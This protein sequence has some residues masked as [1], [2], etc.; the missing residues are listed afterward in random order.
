MKKLLLS[1][2]LALLA[3][4]LTTSAIAQNAAGIAPVITEIM[5]N[6]PEGGNDT[7]EFIE[8]W[9]P[10]G[11]FPL[12]MSGFYFSA[13]IDYTFPTGSEIP[14]GGFIVVAVDSIAFESVFG[15]EALEWDGGALSNGGE[16]ITLRTPGGFVADTVFYDDGGDW[17]S[18]ADQGGYSLVVC[19]PSADNNDPANWSIS[20]NDVGFFS[21]GLDTYADPYQFLPCVTVGVADNE[22]ITTRVFPNPSNG[23]FRIEMDALDQVANLRIYSMTGQV[24]FSES[25]ATGT[26]VLD[27]ATELE[28]GH[29]VLTIENENSW[30]RAKL[31]VQ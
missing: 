29:Y 21:N 22:V 24:V 17:P 18:E 25:V 13:G 6:P 26:T 27:M 30:Q 5:Y 8:I 11:S 3:V 9:N 20:T 28:P 15:Q 4:C 16:G 12:D 1:A 7:L 19:D 14:A 31:S 10:N 2:P 23:A